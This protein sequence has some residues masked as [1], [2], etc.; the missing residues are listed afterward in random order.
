MLFHRSLNEVFRSW[1]HV[2]VL[3]VLR[4]TTVGFTGNQVAREARMHPRSAFKALTALEMLGMIRRQRGGRD[5]LFTLNR[6]HILL[7]EGVLPLL[8]MERLM[9]DRLEAE[10][11]PLLQ[12][13]SSLPFFSEVW[14]GRRRRQDRIWISAVSLTARRKQL[15]YKMRF[16][17]LPRTSTAASE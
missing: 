8:D 13:R 6:D 17:H 2:A 14:P 7:V 4:D 16:I 11:R 15:W 9:I 5:H 3:R 1:T 10:L 12:R